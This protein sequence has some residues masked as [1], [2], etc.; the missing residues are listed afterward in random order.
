M[1]LPSDSGGA[2]LVDPNQVLDS[3]LDGF[4]IVRAIRESGA[5]IDFE[6]IYIN[7]AGAATYHRPV[8]ELVGRRMCGVLPA[9]RSSGL[10]GEYCAV[11]ETGEPRTRTRYDYRD[12]GASGVFDSRSWRYGVDCVAVTWRDV[13]DRE[14]ATAALKA[15]EER[16]R[17]TVEHL[18]DSVSV[19]TA[20][21]DGS[22]RI[23]DFI[24]IFANQ[25]SAALTGHNTGPLEGRRLLEVL[26]DHERNGMFD[27]YRAV[28]DTGQPWVKPTLWYEDVSAD[29]VRRRKA[30]DVRATRVQDGFV[31]VTRDVTEPRLQGEE[32][33]HQR[34]DAVQASQAK[35]QFM[36]NVSHEIR[37]PMNGILGMAEL[38][39]DSDVDSSQRRQLCALRE[40]GQNL[41]HVINDILDYSKV[42]AGKVELEAIDFDLVLAVEGVAGLLATP[43]HDRGLSLSLTFDPAVPRWVCGDPG[44]LRQVLTNLI[45]NAVKF[46]GRGGVEVAVIGGHAD[47]IRF[48][49]AD[50]GIGIDPGQHAAILEPFTQADA[51]TTRRF[52]GTG[53]GLTICRQL[54][55]LMGGALELV[56]QPGEGTTFWFEVPLAAASGREMKGDDERVEPSRAPGVG[57]PHGRRALLVDDN[58]INQM[59]A[60]HLLERLGYDVTVAG[61][62]LEAV[63]MVD[64]GLR[65][66]VVLMDL[67]MPKMDGYQ[68]T[69]AIRRLQGSDGHT[70]IVAMTASA[71]EGDREKCLAA[72]MDD[73][74]SKPVGSRA[75]TAALARCRRNGVGAPV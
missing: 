57:R 7:P 61:D 8:A 52:G 54:V 49:V 35:S 33:A 56:S 67:Q 62:G 27:V 11:L 12:V 19:F 47:V 5:I 21:R 63:E 37:T 42:D 66:D 75:L 59:V 31:V 51:T 28:V 41:L 69:A 73:Y 25:S 38:L 6:W 20:L 29:G 45:G 72:G 1:Q 17:A 40:S 43:A 4:A 14:E 30:I 39:L 9:M 48:E 24:W 55:E 16:F 2:A 32:V 15:S 44:R 74:V 58:V 46:T 71:M 26:P 23:I 34:A 65:F 70:P 10:L 64:S 68:A 18:P 36:A 50:T 3:M 22:N 53:L 13:T 60:T